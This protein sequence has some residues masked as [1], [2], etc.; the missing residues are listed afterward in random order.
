MRKK[1]VK[2]FRRKIGGYFFILTTFFISASILS[3]YFIEK[4]SIYELNKNRLKDIVSIA[5]KQIDADVHSTLIKPKHENKANYKLIKS[6]L[7]IIRDS[8]S[9]IFNI[10]TM[11]YDKSGKIIFVVD[12]E[13]DIVKIAHLGEIY[14]DPSFF[15]KKN[16]KTIKNPIVERD[17]YTDKWGTWLSAYAPFYNSLGK[18]EGVLGIDIKSTVIKQYENNLLENVIIIFAVFF[19]LIIFFGLYF[20]QRISTP[21]ARI[22]KTSEKVIDGDTNIVFKEELNNEIGFLAYSLNRMIKEYRYIVNNLVDLEKTRAAELQKA[23]VEHRIIE[24]T[25]RNSEDRLKTLSEATFE[26]VL[27]LVNNIIIDANETICKMTGY[28]YSEII[29]KNIS[30]FMVFGKNNKGINYD[31][32]KRYDVIIIKKDRKKF[33]AQIQDKIVSYKGRRTRVTTIRD[34]TERKISEQEIRDYGE[35]QELLLRE[36]NHRVKNNL[37]A[38]ISML[39]KEKD[40]MNESNNNNKREFIDNIINR[41][42]ALSTVHSM[43]SVSKWKPLNLGALCTDLVNRLSEKADGKGEITLIIN[44]ADITVNSN[45]AQQMSLVINEIITNSLKYA[46]DSTDKLIITINI[47]D[48]EKDIIM[49]IRDNGQGFS[50]K[51][52]DGDFKNTGIGFNL[53]FGIITKSLSGSVSIENDNGAVFNI[54]IKKMI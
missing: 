7:Q 3:F 44:E 34:V 51:L 12:A 8:V 32:S 24:D 41:V 37:Y 16:I 18:L 23:I 48:E 54:F 40:K 31:S 43:L 6:E 30:L 50:Q 26:G 17:F 25:L 10:Y 19:P 49:K 52:L 4:K 39:Y 35:S 22:I 42:D 1:K 38:I 2:K 27:I 20:A 46:K 33:H 11:R 47:L 53:I 15:L 13:E 5:A 28:S 14:N 29:G 45:Q 21:I 9:D 36:V